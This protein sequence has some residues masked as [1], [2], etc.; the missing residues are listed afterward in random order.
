MNQQELAHG[1]GTK[2]LICEELTKGQH[3]CV[4]SFCNSCLVL[5]LENAT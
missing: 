2:V 3:L 4:D 5:G 1:N